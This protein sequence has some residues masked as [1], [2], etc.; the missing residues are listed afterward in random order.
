MWRVP[1]F[2]LVLGSATTCGLLIVRISLNHQIRQQQDYIAASQQIIASAPDYET[3]WKKLAAGIYEA[4]AHDPALTELLKRHDITVR[5]NSPAT[6]TS[7]P[8][9]PAPATSVAPGPPPAASRPTP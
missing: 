1:Y 9:S 2:L 3:T 8:V 5:V 7:S 4:S 6:T